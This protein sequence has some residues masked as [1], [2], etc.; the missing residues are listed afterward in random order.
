M[1]LEEEWHL[2]IGSFLVYFHTQLLGSGAIRH[3]VAC[4]SAQGWPQACPAGERVSLTQ[5]VPVRL[6][7]AGKGYI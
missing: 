4:L 5:L 7:K 1:G 3:S 2:D 6:Q